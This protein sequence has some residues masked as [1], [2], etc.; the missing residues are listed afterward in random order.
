MDF[1]KYKLG[2]T[3]ALWSTL[4]IAVFGLLSFITMIFGIFQVIALAGVGYGFFA[5]SQEL[6]KAGNPSGVPMK[7]AAFTMFIVAGISLVSSILMASIDLDKIINHGA[8]LVIFGG[9][10]MMAYAV[11][12]FIFK[13]KLGIALDSLGLKAGIMLPGLLVYA[14]GTIVAG[15]GYFVFGLAPGLG[16][17][18]MAGVLSVLGGL[19]ALV[20]EILWIIGMF[21]TT[22]VATAAKQ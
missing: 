14:I 11:F 10:L 19:A 9:L 7:N 8:A 22:G 13:G 6:E 1:Q 16:T 5:A 17:L 2:W 3:I 4:A 18:G 15:F 12:L 20:G 21:Q